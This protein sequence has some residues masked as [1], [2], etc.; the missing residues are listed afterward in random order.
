MFVSW[1]TCRHDVGVLSAD[2]NLIQLYSEMLVATVRSCD[3]LILTSSRD[4]VRSSHSFLLFQV[5]G[6]FLKMKLTILKSALLKIIRT[7]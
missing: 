4:I 1:N 7:T 5:T 2:V 6:D 3:L